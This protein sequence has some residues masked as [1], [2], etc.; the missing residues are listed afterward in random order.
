MKDKQLIRDRYIGPEELATVREFVSL[1]WHKGRTEISK[2]LCRHWDWKQPNGLLKDR[3]CREILL[4]LHRQ[5]NIEL[6]PR[7]YHYQPVGKKSVPSQKLLFEACPVEGQISQFGSL[8][9]SMVRKTSKEKLWNQL[10]HQYHYLGRPLI[11][12][13]HLKYLAY[14]DGRIVACLGWGSAAWRVTSRDN[15]IGWDQDTRKRNLYQV[16]N[17]V[18]FLILP[19]VKIPHLASKILAA[20]TRIL[21]RDWLEFYH[22]PLWLAETFVD[23]SR[24]AGTCYRAAN[25]IHAGNTRGNAK[26][27]ASYHY[28]GITKAV[29]LYPLHK[30]FRERLR[31]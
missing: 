28:H 22:T 4:K 13:S 7:R 19:W 11:V 29:Y 31:V 25:W 2:A 5:G 1:Y 3:A 18:R 14:L 26:K 9:F 23:T 8:T 27:G 20:N 30:W 16:V 15:F 6:P 12:G 24:F 17:N 21:S 10:I